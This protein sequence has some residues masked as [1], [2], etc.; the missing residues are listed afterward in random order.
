MWIYFWSG[1]YIKLIVS[2]IY[3]RH[4]YMSKKKH[5]MNLCKNNIKSGEVMH[6]QESD[7]SSMNKYFQIIF[8]INK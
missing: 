2:S 4:K 1:Y 5:H 6:V 8:I 3:N 7:G